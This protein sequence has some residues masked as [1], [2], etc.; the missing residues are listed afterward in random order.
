LFARAIFNLFAVNQ[1]DHTKNTA[2]LMDDKGQWRLSPFY[3]V[4]PSP[5]P[6]GQHMT[7]FMGHGRQPPLDVV[8]KLAR[9]A[10]FPQWNAARETIQRIVAA[11]ASWDDVAAQQGVAKQTRKR[12]AGWLNGA[13]LQNKVLLD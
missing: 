12:I 3:D 11:L 9:Q 10:G 5:N 8:R 4:T 7:A 1:D 6:T 13:Y 2:F